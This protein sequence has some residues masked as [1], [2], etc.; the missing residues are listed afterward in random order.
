MTIGCGSC[1][2][3]LMTR[4]AGQASRADSIEIEAHLQSCAACRDEHAR[5]SVIGALQQYEPAL[6]TDVRERLVA[7]LT[8]EAVSQGSQAR[9][10]A[11]AGRPIARGFALA[12]AAVVALAWVGSALWKPAARV[13]SGEVLVGERTVT[14]GGRIGDEASL[15]STRGGSVLLDGPR[16]E[17]QAGTTLAWSRPRRAIALERGQVTVDVVPGQGQR[18]RVTTADFIVEVVGTRFTVTPTSVATEHGTVR[19]LTPTENEIAQVTA[20][21]MWS[22]SDH[23]LRT[24]S[25]ATGALAQGVTRFELK[26]PSA[27]AASS[28][29]APAVAAPAPTLDAPL[30]PAAVVAAEGSRRAAPRSH[31]GA[32]DGG[33]AA[34]LDEAHV[35]LADGKAATAR[36][37]VRAAL[38]RPGARSLGAEANLLLAEA[39]LVEKRKAQAITA[40]H[41]VVLRYPRSSAAEGALFAAAELAQEMGRPD[42]ARK[43]LVA[44][45]RRYPHGRFVAE[46][47]ARLARLTHA[48]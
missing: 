25:K 22:L 19:V 1:R 20:G 10:R 13:L 5:W 30:A 39:F 41:G 7:R 26:M 28:P 31:Q 33:A 17:L 4:M 42:A 32:A 37:L 46:T 8:E 6:G 3:R 47:T 29:A 15:S 35:A 9:Q 11:T 14:A 44:Y 38:R 48:P 16:V 34:L 23:D 2:A 12:A 45:L 43:D 21:E 36:Q 40:Y 24:G 18:F 27:P